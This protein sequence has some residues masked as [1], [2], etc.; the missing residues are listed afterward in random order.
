MDIDYPLIGLM[1]RVHF[2][3][4][5]RKNRFVLSKFTKSPAVRD[6]P[7]IFNCDLFYR[8]RFVS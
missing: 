1:M 5:I 6:K 2:V 4:D 7:P 3:D 8:H